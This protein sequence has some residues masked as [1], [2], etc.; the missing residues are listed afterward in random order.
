MSLVTFQTLLRKRNLKQAIAPASAFSNTHGHQSHHIVFSA[1]T[2]PSPGPLLLRCFPQRES[3]EI[4]ER[5]QVQY[6]RRSHTR[7]SEA[8]RPFR[9]KLR[10]HRSTSATSRA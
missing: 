1:T 6:R 9:F 3:C 7:P 2:A 10:K 4:T 5:S 8:Q